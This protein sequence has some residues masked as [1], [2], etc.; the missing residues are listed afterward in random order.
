MY[1]HCQ[2]KG[3]SSDDLLTPA[4]AEQTHDTMARADDHRA[5]AGLA[6]ILLLMVTALGAGMAQAAAAGA[7][8]GGGGGGDSRVPEVGPSVRCKGWHAVMP[9]ETCESVARDA[10]LTVAQLR[11]LNHNVVCAALMNWRHVCVRGVAI[12]G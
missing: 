1:T 4:Q 10:G 7:G 5:V 3:T 12:G 9:G 6:A 2:P 11:V 8:A